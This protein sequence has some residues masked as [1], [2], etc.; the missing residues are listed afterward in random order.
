MELPGRGRQFTTPAARRIDTLVDALSEAIS[1]YLDR[2]FAFFGHSMGALVSF[3]LSHALRA[4]HG[5]EPV[6]LYVA[7]QTAPQLPNDGPLLH[8]L[9]DVELRA[10]LRRIGGT[11]QE[12]LAS[13][14]FMALL[15]P[16]LRADFEV[17]E[18]YTYSQGAPLSCPIVAYGGAD[19]PQVGED[20]LKAWAELTTGAFAFAMLPGGHFF[21]DDNRQALLEALNS[22]LTLWRPPGA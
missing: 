11:P 18:T 13:D 8:K 5:V 9:S 20:D 10:E 22:S 14:D 4:K 1:P 16:T 21:I 7:A 19:D 17:C 6:A 12:V 15:L 2:R 3:E